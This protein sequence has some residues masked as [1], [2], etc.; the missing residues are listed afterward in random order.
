MLEMYRLPPR[1]D[2]GHDF[3]L[4]ESHAQARMEMTTD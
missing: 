3:R 2:L 1:P 4:F